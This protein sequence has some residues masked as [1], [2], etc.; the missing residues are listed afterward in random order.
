MK[1]VVALS[2][3]LFSAAALAGCGPAPAAPEDTLASPLSAFQNTSG[4]PTSAGTPTAPE[5]ALI[6]QNVLK[7]LER[8]FRSFDQ[9][10]D[11][12][13]TVDEMNGSETWFQDDFGHPS[14]Q[15]PGTLAQI[16]RPQEVQTVESNVLE[17]W[18]VE[19]LASR[20]G[21]DRVS[22][23]QFASGESLTDNLGVGAPVT[24]ASLFAQA[25]LDRDG[26]LDP[27][28]L[29]LAFSILY[30]DGDGWGAPIR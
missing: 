18:G 10:H 30:A 21:G 28:E 22:E 5:Q 16:Q 23:A 1:C 26:V 7:G 20:V 27:G 14:S 13:V 9:R 6:D 3:V 11:G 29:E 2:L 19:D 8:E 15:G 17:A 12:A 24:A 25:D 4:L